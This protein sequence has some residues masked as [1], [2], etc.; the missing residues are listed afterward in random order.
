MDKAV[1]AVAA[2]PRPRPSTSTCSAVSAAAGEYAQLLSDPRAVFLLL[3]FVVT[4][5]R[6][7]FY[8]GT[9]SLQLGDMLG[10]RDI[11]VDGEQAPLARDAAAGGCE[12]GT[13]GMLS[14]AEAETAA[15]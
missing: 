5:F 6:L 15:N 9:A 7:V 4:Y 10:L 12:E 11:E 13:Q 14:E 1:A 3:F 8:L 2:S